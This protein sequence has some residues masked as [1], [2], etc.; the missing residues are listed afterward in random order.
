M[1]NSMKKIHGWAAALMLIGLSG[2][3]QAAS[4]GIAAIVG[5]D[6]ITTT[7]LAERRALVMATAGIPA[8]PENQQKLTPRIINL[9]ID[10]TLQL[11]EA[12][13]QSIT[14]TDEELNKAIDEMAT[15][16]GK[17]AESLRS[18]VKRQ[19]LSER[20][21]ESQMRAQL[22]W[23]KVVQRK[24]RRNVTISQDEVARAQKAAATAPGESELRVAA[25][26]IAFQKGKEAAAEKLVEE[27][28][29][30]LK[31]GTEI[32]SV[33]ARYM[34]QPEVQ[35][36]PPV[37]VPEKSLPVPL[38]QSL[39]SAKNGDVAAPMRTPKGVQLLQL[40]DRRTAPKQDESTEYII[41]QAA[42]AVPKKRDKATFTK[43]NEVV[44]AL[45]A[46]MGGCMD[47]SIPKVD[48][49]TQVKFARARLGAMSPEQRSIVTHLEVGAVSEPLT[50]P[51]AVRLVMLCEKIEP[52]E[53]NLP[54]AEAVRQQLFSDKIELEAQK[55]LRNLR[56]DAFIEV[57][58]LGE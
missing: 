47:A 36:N 31:A 15:G 49:P 53:G 56:R 57:K 10:E 35:L 44:N 39:R 32:T 42:I 9:L 17:D 23:T 26:D 12:K 19:N 11:Q 4:V 51:D 27:I 46:D 45:H 33:A 16:R 52:P 48:L 21:L 37:W 34:K 6:V 41:K 58:G 29:L 55:H 2:T 30:Q 43:L 13:R 7:E 20:S 5:D 54:A 40:L 25:I 28:A 1:G 18:F 8:T 22:A 50:A 24:L 3:A 14:V 38:Q